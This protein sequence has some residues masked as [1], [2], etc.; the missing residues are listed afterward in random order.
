MASLIWFIGLLIYLGIFI[1]NRSSLLVFTAA[2][3]VALVF[4]WLL[5]PFSVGASIILSILWLGLIPLNID[6]IRKTYLSKP[7]LNF[8]RRVMPTMSETEQQA[9]DAG[10]VNLAKDLFSG[11]PNWKKMLKS[12]G[13]QLSSEE[14]NFLAGPTEELCQMLDDWEVTHELA[15]LPPHIW[16]FIKDNGF[17]S[18]I[19]PKKYGGL[20]FSA[21]AHSAVIAKV[22]PTCMTAATMIG[23]PNSLGPAELLLKYGTEEQKNYYLPR[24]AKGEEIP[25]FAL[26]SPYAGSDATSMIDNG[27]VCKGQYKGKE[28]VGIKLNFDKRY[29]T[30]APIATVIGLAFKLYDPE[31]L[32]GPET[33]RGITCALL[34]RDLKGMR[35]GRRHFPLNIPFQN[36]PIHGKDVFIPCDFIIGGIE[37]AG[38]GWRMLVE[39]LSV[40]RGI[41]LPSISAGGS[42]AV[43]LATGAYARIRKQFGLPIGKFE[44]IQEVLARI[45]GHTYMLDCI[46]RMTVAAIDRGEKPSVL[47]AMA[48]Y[49]STELAR[50]NSLDAMDIHGGKGICL[51]P[52]NYLGRGYQG[53][54][55]GI[56]VEGANIL[57]RS[58]MIF[59]Q[60]AI[61]AHPYV[62]KEIEAAKQ[63]DANKALAE[64]DKHVFAHI[65]HVISNVVRSVAFAL[66]SSR[67]VR[68]P[69]SSVSRYYQHLTRF[70][71]ILALITDFSM[72]IV[73]GN[74]KRKENLS[75]R[76]AD[77]FSYL[78][79]GSAVL[80]NFHE[81][82]EPDTDLPLVKWSLDTLLHDAQ[83]SIHEVI[84]NFPN[85]PVAL[86]L[87]MLVYPIGQHFK[88]PSDY[89]SH[90]V[91]KLLLKPNP[92]RE[93]FMQ[94]I[95][96][97]EKGAFPMGRLEKTL[98][99]V[100]AAEGAS[101]KV[102][103]AQKEG[104]LDGYEFPAW[105][106]S[107]VK[108]DIISQDDAKLLTETHEAVMEVIN[109]D[110]FDSSELGIKAAKPKTTTGKTI[111]IK[112]VVSN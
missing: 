18:M 8:F 69:N 37:M 46:R 85:Q 57:T 30:L 51:G 40:G 49:H 35:I 4:T 90:L 103:I 62:L 42:S 2:S 92:A 81:A 43:A 110:D 60:G 70:S 33:Y 11:N 82:G 6:S 79:I 71:T 17:F 74:L 12:T 31:H 7:L 96:M 61:R 72:L 104:K 50:K 73:G 45:G 24:L 59:G 65:G 112:K 83:K 20:E 15:D 53:S 19:I 58:L 56:T 48:K 64:F 5:S 28:I 44:A 88:T 14:Q 41:T 101:K 107:A 26:T 76:L 87:R 52:S 32:L 109:V 102:M 21:A 98:K 95:C 1:Y 55:I 68:T 80:K 93:R 106:E 34:P 108:Q 84:R 9:I 63:T 111:P 25:C 66:T 54:P 99:L 97:S 75:A 10:T 3:F 91:A 105:V 22:A 89:L 38:H 100:I 67:V 94:N 29:I 27:I 39:C 23:V 13:F 16:K 86:L 47:T 78:Y 36:G 77:V